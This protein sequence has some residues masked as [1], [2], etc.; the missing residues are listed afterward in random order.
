[1]AYTEDYGG[2]DLSPR[3]KA[4]LGFLEKFIDANGMSPTLRE[5]VA[6][7]GISSTSVVTYNLEL[8]RAKGYLRRDER[9]SRGVEMLGA[10]SRVVTGMD[11]LPIMGEFRQGGVVSL[12]PMPSGSVDLGAKALAGCEGAYALRVAVGDREIGIVAG[13][14]IALAPVESVKMGAMALV[15]TDAGAFIGQWSGAA[16]DGGARVRARVISVIRRY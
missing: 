16:R 5:I 4:I 6:G 7:C 15:D 9:L 14:I 3:G 12:Y 1:M 2:E 13:D 10:R 11:S 8:L